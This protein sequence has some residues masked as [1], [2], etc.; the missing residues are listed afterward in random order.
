MKT[1]KRNEKVAFMKART[2]DKYIRMRG[3][4][5]FTL[6]RNP[7]EYS[8]KYIDEKNERNDIVGYSPSVRY[9][10][11]YIMDDAVHREFYDIT[12]LEYVGEN[13]VRNIV[14]VDLTTSSNTK[15]AYS[16]DWSI[17][18]DSEGDDENTYTFSGTLKAN[19][20]V[21]L[22]TAT[23]DDNWE[24]CNFVSVYDEDL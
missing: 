20:D 22:G 23:S 9:S 2:G 1:M 15:D 8:R 10:F 12:N 24:T 21:I 16:R 5:E 13:A 11:D 14:I 17:V 6:N 3:F 19:G 7:I 18:P 4:T